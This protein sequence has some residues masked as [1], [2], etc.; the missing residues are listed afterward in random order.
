[1]GQLATHWKRIGRS[2]KTID[3]RTIEPI[4]L[5]QAAANYKPELYTA[6]IWPEHF[7]WYN[8]GKIVELKSDSNEEGGVDLF[9]KIAP[10]Q[11]YLDAIKYG[12]KLFTSMELLPN[13]RDT[14]QFYLTGCAATDSPASA[15]TSEMRFSASKNKDFDST[16]ALLS[17]HIELTNHTID[18]EEQAPSWFTKLF[19][20]KTEDDM[21]KQLIEKL[22][23]DL[24][25]LTEQFAALNKGGK[26]AGDNMPDEDKETDHFATLTES[27]KALDERFSAFEKDHGSEEEDDTTLKLTAMQTAL[28]DL[29]GKFTEALKE[30]GGTHAGEETGGD[31]LNA[32]V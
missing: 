9:A 14:D 23:G 24:T 22:Q 13:F 30:T 12:Q 16:A 7:R 8:F 20:N 28:D 18:S 11:Y 21:D 25:A 26:P 10:N 29:T 17:E 15:G 32:Y 3:G 31:D 2:G 1:M 19:K 6:L 4:A 27:I 5:T